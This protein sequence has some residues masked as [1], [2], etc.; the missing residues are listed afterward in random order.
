MQ[1]RTLLDRLSVSTQTAALTTLIFAAAIMAHVSG[2]EER[3]GDEKKLDRQKNS[4]TAAHERPATRDF[5][6]KKEVA[7]GSGGTL[8]LEADR[9]SVEVIPAVVDHVSVEVIRSIREKDAHKAEAILKHHEVAISKEGND[10]IVKSRL[11]PIAIENLALDR[12]GIDV[13]EDVRQ[14]VKNAIRKRFRNIH[15]RVTVPAKYNLKLK[16][17]GR[18]IVCGDIGGQARCTTSGG[19]IKLGKIAGRVVATTSGGSLQLAAAGDSVELRT[20]GGSVRAGDIHGDAVVATSGGSISLGRVRGR[21]SAKTSG[22]SIRILDAGG[23]IEAITS[24]GSVKAVISRQ[25][26][27]DSYFATTGGSVNVALAKGLA[28]NFEHLGHG[29][30]SGPFLKDAG[31]QPR[32]AKLNG[33]GPKL[34][35]KGN[36]RFTYFAAK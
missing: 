20:S 15:F 27:A 3:S 9:G 34:V 4:P 17:G 26:K 24:G 6:I 19:G 11:K 35:T 10:A 36:A 8:T 33:G 2:G 18:N 16:T 12:V 23:A 13:S 29:K 1:K 25:P 22:G 7:V 28:F 14:A 30:A 5:V 31:R 21:V 32:T